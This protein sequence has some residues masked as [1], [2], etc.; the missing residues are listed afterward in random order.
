M[1]EL[2][3]AVDIGGTKILV[4]LVDA[5][6]TIVASEQVAT[7]AR[8]GAEAIIAAVAGLAKQVLAAAPSRVSRCGVGTAGVVG[9]HGEITS[10]TDHLSGWAGTQLQ[11]RLIAELGMPVT[12]LNDVQASG[13]C[14]GVLG[15]ARGKR[16]ALIVALGTGVGGS[17]VRN[18]QVERG[19]Y[20]IA[21]SVGHH[22]SPLRQGRPCPCGGTDHL[23]AYASG[24]AMELEY[25]RRTGRAIRLR[26]I[27]A[28]AEADDAEAGAVIAEAAEVLG[29]VLGS[30][31]N[32]V[33]AEVIVVAGGVLALG[34]RLLEP[35]RAA[36]RREALGLSR[37]VQIVP[38]R[39]G[40]T[41]C[42]I[43]AALAAFGAA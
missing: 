25:E 40:P 21:G 26:E 6:G 19:A 38:A 12:V 5:E 7:P 33:D 35:A 9:E 29:A 11:Q 8:E 10:A 28:L 31:N 22:L 43:G 20:G 2:V 1:S 36:A 24:T 13:L 41:A 15:A 39:F 17:L 23:E 14:E 4:G 34:D 3:L 16:S 30:A 18:G 32:V 37:A 42:L 27:A